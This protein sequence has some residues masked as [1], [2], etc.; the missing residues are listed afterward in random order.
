M[1][2][3]GDYEAGKELLLIVEDEDERQEWKRKRKM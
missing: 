3:K 2:V 1:L